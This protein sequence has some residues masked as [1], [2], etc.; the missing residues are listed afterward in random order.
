MS[1]RLARQVK[2]PEESIE[3]LTLVQIEAA[4]VE[5]PPELILAVIEVERN[6]DRYADSV[7]GAL[8]LM[9]IMP[10]LL[11]EIGRP[12]DNLLHTD[13]NLSYGCSILRFYLD[14]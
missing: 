7:A 12:N 10:F 14:K 13:T 11:D 8:G 1:R 3:L 2:D 5:L 9:K 4:R 6:L